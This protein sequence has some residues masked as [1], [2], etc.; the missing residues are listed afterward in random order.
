MRVAVIGAGPAGITAAYQLAKR[1]VDV[2]VFEASGEIGGLARS[3]S[4]WG[5]RVDLGPHRFFSQDR[6]VNELWL[7]VVGRDYAM[8]DRTT[9]IFYRD[10]FFRYPLEPMDALPKLGLVE[11][12]RCL[13]SYASTRLS[14]PQIP[15][16]AS[17][18]Q[19]VT[20]RFGRRLYEVFFKTYSEKLWGIPCSELDA[21]F[22]AQRIKKLSLYEAIK[23]AFVRRQRSEHKTLVDRFAYPLGGTGIV[24][25]RMAERVRE[26]GGR[27]HLRSPV[28]RVLVERGRACGLAL[29]D[30]RTVTCDHVIST[31]PFTLL[32][33]SL[34]DVPAPVTSA[35]ASLTFRNT[36]LVY[37]DVQATNLFP[38]QWLYIHEPSLGVGRVTNFRNWVPQLYGSQKSSILALEYWCNDGDALWGEADGSLI[39]RATRELEATGLLRGAPVARGHVVRIRR[40]YP[41]YRR[42]YKEHVAQIADYLQSAVQGLIPI[43][44]YGSFKYNN[45]DHSILMGML[46]ADNVCRSAKHDLWAVNT[47]YDTYEEAATIGETG[48]ELQHAGA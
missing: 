7:E 4:L 25:E 2:D 8:V 35:A 29:A 33:R 18:E 1:G 44:R 41:V 28:D 37:L 19:W 34:P 30:G 32:V 23:H 11:A 38:D 45:Q 13:G 20:C 46:A 12:A 9:H 6:R 22:A 39:G 24:Y 27:V 17:F 31:M 48:L 14:S 5:Q 36:I 43:G 10:R 3:F 16:Q 21:D 40:C 15:D 47:D 26:N 42:G